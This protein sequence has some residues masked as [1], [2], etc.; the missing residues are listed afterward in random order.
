MSDRYPNSDSGASVDLSEEDKR[1]L[2]VEHRRAQNREYARDARKRKKQ[3]KDAL[4]SATPTPQ[5]LNAA[6]DD[7]RRMILLYARERY[8]L[9][10]A[11]VDISSAVATHHLWD[12]PPPVSRASATMH[13]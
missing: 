8:A 9:E 3:L 4:K 13:L 5:A 1:D 7:M 2:L 11:G 6:Y 12:H 10:R